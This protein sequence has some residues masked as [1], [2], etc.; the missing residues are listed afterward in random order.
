MNEPAF[1]TEI[2]L[3]DRLREQT[4]RFPSAEGDC[5]LVGNLLLPDRPRPVGLVFVHGWSGVRGGPHGLLTAT[6][7][8]LAG[9]GFASLRFDLGGRGESGGDGLRTTLPGMA[10]DVEAATR[11]LVQNATLEGVVLF[12]MCSGGNVAIGSLPRLEKVTGLVLL[13]VYPFSDGDAFSRDV[14]RTWHFAQV[15]WHKLGQAET[16]R[17]LAR[18]DIRFRQV[19]NVLFGHFRRGSAAREGTAATPEETSPPA[20]P[21]KKHLA[22][23]LCRVP[24]LMLYGGADP[25]AAAARKYYEE[26]AGEHDLPVRF[27]E[28]PGANH[29]FS[30]RAWKAKIA[31]LS[32]EFCARLCPR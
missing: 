32:Q 8:R 6:A 5:E 11:F 15:Y 1:Q 22:N 3:T 27:V 28:L 9:D 19:F 7:R 25:D 20:A 12:G 29:N 4:V 26:Y 30:S 18:G 23:L 31:R 13:S 2:R 10:A 24:C 16:W 21:P 17:R 14:H